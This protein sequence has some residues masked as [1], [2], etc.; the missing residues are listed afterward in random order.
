MKFD[1][2]INPK[3][4]SASLNINAADVKNE[5]DLKDT[6]SLISIISAD[7]YLDPELEIDQLEEIINKAKEEKK[8]IEIIIDEDGIELE[9]IGV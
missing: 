7:F 8:S 4:H 2:Q 5:K 6:L 9:F 1:F 3:N